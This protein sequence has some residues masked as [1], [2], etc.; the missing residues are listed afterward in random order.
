MYQ[1]SVSRRLAGVLAPG[2]GDTTV[3]LG[4]A[5]LTRCT[6][7]LAGVRGDGVRAGYDPAGAVAAAIC[8]AECERRGPH[9]LRVEELCRAALD[10]RADRGRA[11]AELVATTRL[12]QS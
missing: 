1:P 6:V 8:D 4:H 5:A 2:A 9:A 12:E 7:E 3:V 10:A 11:R